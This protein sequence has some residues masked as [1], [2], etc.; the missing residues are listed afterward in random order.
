VQAST[1]VAVGSPVEERVAVVVAELL[2]LGSVDAGENIFLVGG[3]SMLAMQ[4]VARI[5][6]DFGVR[7]TLRQV[8]ETPT[9]GGIAAAVV[10]RMPGI[11]AGAGS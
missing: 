11:A 4:L 7:L 9:V 10:G 6:Q 1:P 2:K 8:F 5:K 3:H